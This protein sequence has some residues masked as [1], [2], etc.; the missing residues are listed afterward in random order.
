MKLDVE[1]EMGKSTQLQQQQQQQLKQQ[2]HKMH[3]IEF[4]FVNW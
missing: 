2:Q 4:K 3:N 1:E